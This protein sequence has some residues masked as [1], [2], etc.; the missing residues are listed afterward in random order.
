MA[1]VSTQVR[2]NSSVNS[3]DI[4]SLFLDDVYIGD[5]Y[6]Q[7]IRKVTASTS[8]M[9]TIAG[10]GTTGYS[11]D[12]GQATSASLYLPTGVAVDTSGTLPTFFC[13]SLFTHTSW[14]VTFTSAILITIE[15]AR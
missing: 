2:T 12:N 11:G 14:Q 8:I 9:S 1:C 10:A 5:P 4:N 15:S 6:N 13:Y 7:R 3:Y